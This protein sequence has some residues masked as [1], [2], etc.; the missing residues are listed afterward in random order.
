M[1]VARIT[2]QDT[3]MPIPHFAPIGSPV[4]AGTVQDGTGVM[5][6]TEE[7]RPISEAVLQLS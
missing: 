2:K 3:P 7:N 4:E 6:E 5:E 1:M